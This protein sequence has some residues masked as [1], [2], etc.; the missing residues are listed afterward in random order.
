ME[1]PFFGQ[2]H[3]I[4][5]KEEAFAEAMREVMAASRWEAGRSRRDGKLFCVH[6]R[7]KDEEAFEVRARLAHTVKFL[8]R[9]EE[10][11]K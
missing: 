4:A 9:E 10:A 3:V 5:E 8:E 1:F 2:F 6:S 11:M 7:W